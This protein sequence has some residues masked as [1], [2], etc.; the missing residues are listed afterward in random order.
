MKRE[1][2]EGALLQEFSPRAKRRPWWHALGYFSLGSADP[3]GFDP[4]RYPRNAQAKDL[5]RIGRDFY[6][7]LGRFDEEIQK[8][9]LEAKR[10]S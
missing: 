5:E 3:T 7:A 9:G 10:G 8:N 4:P 1:L 2:P 6:A